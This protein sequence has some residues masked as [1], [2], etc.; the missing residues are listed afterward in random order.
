MAFTLPKG[1]SKQFLGLEDVLRERNNQ[2][3]PKELHPDEKMNWILFTCCSWT[4]LF[5]FKQ[6]VVGSLM[7]RKFAALF[8]S[9][10][11]KNPRFWPSS[12]ENFVWIRLQSSNFRRNATFSF[13]CPN[14]SPWLE[15]NKTYYQAVFGQRFHILR[16]SIFDRD[17][18]FFKKWKRSFSFSTL[19]WVIFIFRSFWVILI[20]SFRSHH[21]LSCLQSSKILKY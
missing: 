19:E 17:S 14:Q 13:G 18:N 12:F 5:S 11:K 4:V 7:Q 16:R 15:S 8:S 21:Q 1:T 6:V 20:F 9:D 2:L 3:G 10:K